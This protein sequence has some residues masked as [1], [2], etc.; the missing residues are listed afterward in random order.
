[1]NKIVRILFAALTAALLLG[2]CAS[3]GSKFT[4]TGGGV[5]SVHLGQPITAVANLTFNNP[6][7]KVKVSAVSGKV[8]SGETAL[9]GLTA[10]DFEIPARSETT[11]AIPVEANLEPG[12]GIRT[13]MKLVASGDFEDLTAD[14]TFTASGFLGIRKT[15]TIEDIPVKDLLRML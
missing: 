2:G 6:S 9:L 3:Q 1:M 11:V 15:Q 14:I 8:K 5:E 7:Q 13:I 12:V 10:E 4:I